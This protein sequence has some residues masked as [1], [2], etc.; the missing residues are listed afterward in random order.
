MG[1]SHDEQSVA[2][3]R[4]EVHRTKGREMSVYVDR[5]RNRLGRMV[6]CHMLADTVE[7]LH[8]MAERIGMKREW[9]QPKSTPHYDVSLERRR[10]ALQYGAVE[11]D[12]YKVVELIR[13][14]RERTTP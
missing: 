7:E 5:S 4:Q 8:A 11:A 9:F 3:S 6:M 1:A 14:Y 12:K 10:L 13:A 2:F